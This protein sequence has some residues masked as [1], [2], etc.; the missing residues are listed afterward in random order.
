[1]I[2]DA[3][4]VARLAQQPALLARMK[5]LAEVADFMSPA[6][7]RAVVLQTFLALDWL[8]GGGRLCLFEGALIGVVPIR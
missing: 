3:S 7:L 5:L 1:M 2:W 8:L 6:R 4:S